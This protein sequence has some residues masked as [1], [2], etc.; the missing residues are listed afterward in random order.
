M[1]STTTLRHIPLEKAH[2]LV[3]AKK[4]RWRTADSI[5]LGSDENYK[6]DFNRRGVWIPRESGPRGPLVLQMDFG[7]RDVQL[8]E[9]R[10]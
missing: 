2:E 1:D 5:I 8:A 6:P 4:A 3:N 10:R 9:M 7:K